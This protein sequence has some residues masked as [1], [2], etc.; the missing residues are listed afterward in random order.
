MKYKYGQISLKR[1]E[2]NDY[3]IYELDSF[4]KNLQDFL[5]NLEISIY[6]LNS[7]INEMKA[8][9]DIASFLDINE[10]ILMRKIEA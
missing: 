5:N 7:L 3:D 8:K 6:K 4:H 9:K 2:C 1:S 10:S